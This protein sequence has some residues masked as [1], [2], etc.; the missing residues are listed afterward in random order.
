MDQHS[1][2]LGLSLGI[3]WFHSGSSSLEWTK[4]SRLK[5]LRSEFFEQKRFREKLSDLF[6][7]QTHFWLDV[8]FWAQNT[9]DRSRHCSDPTGRKIEFDS[10]R[11]SAILE[12]QIL[13]PKRL[14]QYKTAPE[15]SGLFWG[16]RRAERASRPHHRSQ[17]LQRNWKHYNSSLRMNQVLLLSYKQLYHVVWVKQLKPQQENLH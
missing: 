12:A 3:V 14:Y 4:F 2:I 5:P 16:R 8:Q 15:S 1:N 7:F 9:N 17:Q 13:L 6:L 10:E 11:N